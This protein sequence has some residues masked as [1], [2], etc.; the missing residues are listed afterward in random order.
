M[1]SEKSNKEITEQALTTPAVSGSYYWVKLMADD[2]HEPA[3]AV[4]LLG[5]MNFQ[6][7]NGVSAPCKQV[8]DY[9]ECNYR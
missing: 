4:N 2:K 5:L 6:F 7:F 1:N 9:S 3:M 8:S